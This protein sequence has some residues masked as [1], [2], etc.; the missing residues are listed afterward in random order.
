M[1]K[2]EWQEGYGAFFYGKSQV[3]DVINYIEIQ[4]LHHKKTTF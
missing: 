4:E 1:G 2:F 3:K